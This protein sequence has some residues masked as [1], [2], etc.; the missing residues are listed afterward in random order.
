MDGRDAALG[1]P[2]FA[3]QATLNMNNPDFQRSQTGLTTSSTS[4][5]GEKNSGSG[6]PLDS[7]DSSNPPA[8]HLFSIANNPISLHVGNNPNSK[9]NINC[10]NFSTSSNLASQVPIFLPT[11]NSD[12][13][14][15]NGFMKSLSTSG[16]VNGNSAP[17]SLVPNSIIADNSTPE[18]TDVENNVD[19][20]FPPPSDA[21]KASNRF[22]VKT[23]Y[24]PQL[25]FNNKLASS[26]APS[27][28]GTNTGAAIPSA[29]T[30]SIKPS[31]VSSVFGSTAQ[32]AGNE[33]SNSASFLRSSD[34]L[35]QME[36]EIR[37][38]KE[39][40]AQLEKEN[41]ALKFRHGLLQQLVSLRSQQM[42][43]MRGPISPMEFVLSSPAPSAPSFSSDVTVSSTR[44]FESSSLSRE[45]EAEREGEGGGEG[46]GDV[47]EFKRNGE[48][49]EGE[50]RGDEERVSKRETSVDT[51][52][53]SDHCSN[54]ILNGLSDVN[55]T[56]S[57][58]TL[59]VSRS[60]FGNEGNVNDSNDSNSNNSS[61]NNSSNDDRDLATSKNT[62]SNNLN[63]SA[64]FNRISHTNNDSRNT[65]SL[66]PAGSA[67]SSPPFN[68]VASKGTVSD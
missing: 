59:I 15:V 37:S 39:H 31:S 30:H 50:A 56:T 20:F 67:S 51:S 25:I 41:A 22:I 36:D 46:I 12:P 54:C 55:G 9:S 17:G 6:T 42:E 40:V 16:I 48:R 62:N 34:R 33:S 3:R 63:S 18:N 5:L 35:R 21:F 8:E 64:D 11:N 1:L 66:S 14:G 60:N 45:G 19:F 28:L 61:C 49:G 23:E 32:E 2:G 13:N 68:A 47:E 38:K 57:Q 24:S 52:N 26:A 65:G 7:N 44:A 43:T 4:F 29:T 58:E 10:N 53:N 27:M